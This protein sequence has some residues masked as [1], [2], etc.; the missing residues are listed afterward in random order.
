MGRK[1]LPVFKIK[2]DA[3]YQ[4]VEGMHK[5]VNNTFIHIESTK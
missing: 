5:F 4:P 1:N 3:W 2:N